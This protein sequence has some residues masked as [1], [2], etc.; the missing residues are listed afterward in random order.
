MSRNSFQLSIGQRAD[1]RVF[2]NLFIGGQRFRYSN[3]ECIQEKIYPNK[4]LTAVDRWQKASLLK[5][6]MHIA[7]ENGWS[8]VRT[9]SVVTS[10]GETLE[11]KAQ[12]RL[13]LP[14]SYQY[15]RDLRCLVQKWN[16]YPSRKELGVLPLAEIERDDVLKF[17]KW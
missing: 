2:L 11:Q 15:L 8:P 9:I 4:C 10:F 17:I 13:Q 1:G 16:R 12:E 3:G 6:K 14:Y 5:A 7:L